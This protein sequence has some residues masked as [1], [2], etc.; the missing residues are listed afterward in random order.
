MDDISQHVFLPEWLSGVELT[1]VEEVVLVG[2]G[3]HSDHKEISLG[4]N[5]AAKDKNQTT[6]QK[7]DHSS[8][9]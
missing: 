5:D 9:W 8:V 2:A 3:E 1:V 4:Q 7:S 6:R